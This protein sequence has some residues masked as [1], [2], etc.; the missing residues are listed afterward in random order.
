MNGQVI[1]T[2]PGQRELDLATFPDAATA[3]VTVVD[4]TPWVAD[5]TLRDSYLTQT[6]SWNIRPDPEPEAK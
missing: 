6:A 2:E 1:E 4:D 5:D 3:S